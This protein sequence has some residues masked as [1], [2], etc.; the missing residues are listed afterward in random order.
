MKERNFLSVVQL[1]SFPFPPALAHLLKIAYE[2]ACDNFAENV[3]Y[4]EVRFAPQLH[5]SPELD[6][7]AVITAVNSVGRL[8]M[9]TQ[10]GKKRGKRND[11]RAEMERV[12]ENIRRREREGEN[13]RRKK[14]T[15]VMKRI[16]K[17]KGK[18]EKGEEKEHRDENGLFFKK[19]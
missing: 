5:A 13:E 18:R 12:Y 8:A 9:C 11:T 7:E 19:I 2:F 14:A 10:A 16:E 6:M 15:T 4:F 1:F 17:R 3:I